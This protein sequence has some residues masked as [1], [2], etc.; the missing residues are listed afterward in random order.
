MFV[1][2]ARFDRFAG[3]RTRAFTRDNPQIHDSVIGHT[4]E[5]FARAWTD[6]SWTDRSWTDRVSCLHRPPCQRSY[7]RYWFQRQG[8]C[9]YCGESAAEPDRFQIRKTQEIVE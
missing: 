3:K 5:R 9:D 7:C 1:R 4:S 2:C 8:Y 6:R